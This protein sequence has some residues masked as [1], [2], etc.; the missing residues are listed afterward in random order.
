MKR[1]KNKNV[2][3]F[4]PGVEVKF[5]PEMTLRCDQS[6]L[7]L[8]D[9]DMEKLNDRYEELYKKVKDS[10]HISIDQQKLEEY[11]LLQKYAFMVVELSRKRRKEYFEAQA[12]IEADESY[13]IPARKTRFLWLRRLFRRPTQNRAQDIIDIEADLN[14][15][16]YFRQREAEN[17]QHAKMLDALEQ[18]GTPETSEQPGAPDAPADVLEQPGTAEQPGEEAKKR[19][20]R[21]TSERATAELNEI[22]QEVDDAQ[23]LTSTSSDTPP[24][25]QLPGQINIE[26]IK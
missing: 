24:P 22:R 15:E 12:K 11:A 10:S 14:A 2:I 8:T 16:D 9:E 21:R 6:E 5:S 4:K 3:E 26:D 13:I 23:A 19:R 20:R 7:Y 17:E 18:A 1:R 25:A